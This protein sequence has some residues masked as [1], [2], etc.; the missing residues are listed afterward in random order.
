[1]DCY[2]QE[3]PCEVMG[4]NCTNIDKCVNKGNF[5]M[6]GKCVR[7]QFDSD[8]RCCIDLVGSYGNL[9]NNFFFN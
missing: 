7:Q 5:V 3:A 4:G 2:L 1:M 6:P 8:I 9:L